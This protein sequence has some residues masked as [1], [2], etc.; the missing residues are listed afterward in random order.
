MAYKNDPRVD[1]AR[2]RTM[3]EVVDRL[4]LPDLVMLGNERTGPCPRPGCGGRDRFSV[5]VKDGVWRC[6][7]CDPKGGDALKLVQH[8][9]GCDF[10]GAVE[11]LEGTDAREIDPAELARLKKAREAAD[12]LAERDR[13]KYRAYARRRAVEIWRSALPFA[14]S[15]AQTY[16][17]ARGVDLRGLPF[18]FACLRYL[19]AHGY[20][21]KIG[22]KSRLIHSGPCMIAAIQ[23]PDARLIGIHQTWIDPA[24]PGEK[25][26]IRHPDTGEA[27]PAKTVQGSMKGGAIRLT[28]NLCMSA[29]VMGEGIETTGT[30]LVG[31]AVLGASYWVGVSLGNIG[32][33]QTARHSGIPLLSDEGAFVPPG[34][35]DRFVLIEDGDSEP[36]MTRAALTA[37]IRRAMSAKPGLR[38]HVV[39]AGDGVDLND[40][41]KGVPRAPDT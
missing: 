38:G 16:L 4:S 37:G 9:M 28:G 8:V 2:L 10:M 35:V 34:N 29:L 25:A 31:D 1:R 15:E 20:V 26:A 3:S 32:G 21:K 18:S 33:K 5:N 39:P 30:A 40:L 12:A 23:G 22:R 27:M 14:G 19:P 41:V 6:R 11:W 36:V 13:E 24:R 7:Q 17:A